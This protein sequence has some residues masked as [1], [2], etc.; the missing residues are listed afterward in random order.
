MKITHN[1]SLYRIT[2]GIINLFSNIKVPDEYFIFF[3]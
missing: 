3:M 1:A 2:A